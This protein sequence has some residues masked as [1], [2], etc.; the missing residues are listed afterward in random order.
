MAKHDF[1]ASNIF[2]ITQA[3]TYRCQVL[4]YHTRLSRLYLRVFHEQR[5]TPIFYLL[6]TDV[7]YMEC[8]MGWTGANFCIGSQDECIEL[9]LKVGMI[10]Q[11]I[12]RF[13]D[14]YASI[15]DIARLY[16]IDLPG[17][18]LKWIAGSASMLQT[19]PPNIEG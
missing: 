19:L 16:Y 2:N 1:G 4:H 9:M 13:P 18:T 11:A 5:E 6:F 10:G 8:P 3:D 17:T 7:G 15:T 12:L 14:A